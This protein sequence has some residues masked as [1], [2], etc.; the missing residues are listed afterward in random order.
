MKWENLKIE[1]KVAFNEKEVVIKNIR[2]QLLSL[3]GFG[4]EGPMEAAAY[5]LENN[6][7]YEEALNWIDLSISRHPVFQN[8]IIK[9]EL[10]EKME[11][12]SEAE[13]L[14]DETFDNSSE[15]EL[16]LYGYKL[17]NENK[18]DEAIEIFRKNLNRF[19]TSWNCYDSYAE[20]LLKKGDVSK[21]KEN[22]KKA[23][24]LAPEDQKERID[25]LI[26]TLGAK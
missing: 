16:N 19:S 8:K 3:P 20:S 21:A 15:N 23:L 12:P 10:L 11:N 5:C 1:F 25:N 13:K 26:R 7:N 9:V 24:E 22:Y 18:I 14:K 4:W 17:L 2:Q 6:I